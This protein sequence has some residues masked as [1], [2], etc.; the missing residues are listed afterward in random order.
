[1]IKFGSHC[2]PALT[3]SHQTQQRDFGENFRN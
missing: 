3:L 1:M 2:S